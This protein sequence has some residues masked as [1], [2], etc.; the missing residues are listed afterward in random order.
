MKTVILI[1]GSGGCGKSTFVD[2]CKIFNK[3][4]I[5]LS[6]VDYV[7]EVARTLGWDGVKDERSRRF[8]HNLKIALEEWDDSPNIKVM[9]AIE[10][11][12]DHTIFFINVREIKGIKQLHKIFTQMEDIKCYTV[13]VK[14]PNVMQITS[15]EADANVNNYKYD[16]IIENDGTLGNLLD[17][18][19]AFL[20]EIMW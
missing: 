3:Q 20:D 16:Y 8:L 15:N 11:D 1:N 10:K 12:T 17:K 19:G 5:E 18:A 6:T 9:Q 14:N 7:K 4:A 2:F 13:L